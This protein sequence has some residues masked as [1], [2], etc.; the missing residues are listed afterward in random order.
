MRGLVKELDNFSYISRI[1]HHKAEHVH[2]TR[3]VS[4]LSY[5]SGII[6]CMRGLV[7]GTY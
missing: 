5:I 3:Q 6:Q 4:L 7:R 2:R 1:I